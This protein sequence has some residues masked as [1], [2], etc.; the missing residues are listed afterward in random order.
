MSNEKP[1]MLLVEDL[2]FQSH[3][4]TN[5]LEFIRVLLGNQNYFYDPYFGVKHQMNPFALLLTNTISDDSETCGEPESKLAYYTN[6][7]LLDSQGK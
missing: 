3:I 1:P 6:R 5:A 2:H 7:V 4:Q